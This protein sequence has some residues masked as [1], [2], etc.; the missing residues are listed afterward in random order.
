[1]I[2]DLSQ[3][4]KCPLCHE[5]WL[6]HSTPE[7]KF[8]V[9]TKPKCMISIRISDPMFGTWDD[10]KRFERVPCTQ[11]G[12]P[13][14]F[15]CRSDQYKKWMCPDLLGCGTTVETEDPE[16]HYRGRPQVT[17]QGKDCAA[18]LS[19]HPNQKWE[20]ILGLAGWKWVSLTGQSDTMLLCKPCLQ[21]FMLV[22]H[23]D[24][25]TGIPRKIA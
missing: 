20:D 3:P 24:P 19:R 10:E 9:C 12:K 13:M 16:I 22:H 8:M 18:M 25:A 14:R 11:C 7:G 2:I 23:I 5:R 15:F 4:Q 6:L 17:C 1:M 21:A